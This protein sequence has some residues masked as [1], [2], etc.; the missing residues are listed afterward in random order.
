MSIPLNTISVARVSH[1]GGVDDGKGVYFD[2][3]VEDGSTVRI[4][5]PH[6]LVS[7]F[8]AMMM[9]FAGEAR[10]DRDDSGADRGEP[11]EF[12][13]MLACQ[14]IQIAPLADLT[15]VAIQFLIQ[16]GV[17]MV[18]PLENRFI[19]QMAASL[20]KWHSGLDDSRSPS[21]Q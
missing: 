19:P 8:I 3:Q 7:A 2:A 10:K 5:M 20:M 9:A 13:Q 12:A 4:V 18:F 16:P 14:S 17:S 15:G 1:G 21:S 11:L 6:T